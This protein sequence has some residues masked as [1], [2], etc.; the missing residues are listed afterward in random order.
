MREFVRLYSEFTDT[1]AFEHVNPNVI[2][3]LYI[4]CEEDD[5]V[6]VKVHYW[7]DDTPESIPFSDYKEAQRFIKR[8]GEIK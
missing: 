1:S 6:W 8:V 4:D 7:L 2:R 3:R 5:I